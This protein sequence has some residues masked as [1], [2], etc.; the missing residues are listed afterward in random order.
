M[1]PQIYVDD[2]VFGSN[3]KKVLD[4]FVDQMKSEFQMSIVGEMNYFLGLRVKW[5]KDGIFFSQSEYARNLVNKISLDKANHKITH[6]ATTM[7]LTK[8]DVVTDVAHRHY[9][10]A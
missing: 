2:I 4:M 5:L 1:I 7:K 6:V 8:D 10:E 9:T 3:N